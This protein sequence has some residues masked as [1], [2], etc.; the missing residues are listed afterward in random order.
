[1]DELREIFDYFPHFVLFLLIFL[2]ILLFLALS[3]KKENRAEE[4]SGGTNAKL[5]IVA[6]DLGRKIKS[7]I[8]TTLQHP[9]EEL[10]N[11]AA[12]RLQLCE[13]SFLIE[14]ETQTEEEKQ[15]WDDVYYHLSYR[16]EDVE[17]AFRFL[18]QIQH[19]GK[20]THQT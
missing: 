4:E 19:L 16:I 18:E 14:E 15:R 13:F 17:S 12:L 5:Q 9:V 20:D 1:M 7:C 3:R 8:R 2:I 6:D 10:K 11:L